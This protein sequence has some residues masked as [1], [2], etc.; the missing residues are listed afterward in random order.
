MDK[1][2]VLPVQD[3]FTLVG[4]GAA[5]VQRDADWEV[6]KAKDAEWREWLRPT[7]ALAAAML[8]GIMDEKSLW[9]DM[10]G[11]E[12][13]AHVVYQKILKILRHFEKQGIE[14]PAGIPEHLLPKPSEIRGLWKEPETVACPDVLHELSPN[15]R[16]DGCPD[17]EGAGK[18]P[19]E[20][21]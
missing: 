11:Y 18:V 6:L 19:K 9:P 21:P 2:K 20:A 17:C 8:H 16:E 7:L 1:D 10:C 14:P 4:K 3:F 5:I 13:Q 12:C 15:R